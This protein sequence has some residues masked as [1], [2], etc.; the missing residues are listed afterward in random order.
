MKKTLN[1]YFSATD[2]TKAAAQRLAKE[3]NA[4]LKEGVSAV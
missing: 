2:T 1:V 4:D 3:H